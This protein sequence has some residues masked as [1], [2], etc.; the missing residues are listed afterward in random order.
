M[1]STSGPTHDFQ[2][3]SRE[4]FLRIASG[5]TDTDFNVDRANGG[6]TSGATRPQSVRKDKTTGMKGTLAR[7]AWVYVGIGLLVTPLFFVLDR[8][9]RGILSLAAALALLPAILIAYRIHRL[10]P[11]IVGMFSL[12]GTLY[13]LQEEFG[14]VEG[15][16]KHASPAF[17]VV[18]LAANVVVVS[19]LAYTVSRRRGNFSW[20]DIVDGLMIALAGWMIAWVML[21]QP[22]LGN[23]EH[24]LGE[25][26]LN[27]ANLPIMLPMLVLTIALAMSGV[28]RSPAT[29]LVVSAVLLS[30]IG[31]SIA[32]FFKFEQSGA[33][34]SITAVCFFIAL[35]LGGAAFVHPSSADLMVFAPRSHRLQLTRRLL[36]TGASLAL[37]MMLI[38]LVPSESTVD[39]YVKAIS[40]MAIVVLASIRI[41]E[42]TRAHVRA[43]DHL[44]ESALT[45]SL[46]GLPNRPAILDK[47]I[48]S[49][50]STGRHSGRPTLVIFDIDRF[51]NINDSLGHQAGDEVLR[52]VSERLQAAAES[53]GAVVGRRS[54]D[55]FMILDLNADTSDQALANAEFLHAVFKQPLS[56]S[57]GVVFLT[58]SGGV[59]TMPASGA[60]QAEDLFRMADIAMYKAKDAGRDGLALYR[61]SMQQHLTARMEIENALYGA[62]DRKE[63]RMFHQPIID[64]E[65]GNITGFESL[66]RWQRSDGTLLAPTQFIAIAEETGIISSIG[67]WAILEALNQLR[68]WIDGGL[69]SDRTTI[70]VNVS[71]RQLA[72]PHF[73]DSVTEALAR[74]RVSPS[75][76]WLEVTE[77]I[78]IAEPELARGALEQ[79]RAAGVR[80]SLDDFGTGYS[81][82]SLLQQFPIHQIK[83]DR[84]FV[85]GIAEG[86]HDASLVRTVI[87]M[88]ESLGMDV[89]AE[90]VET[91]QQ[92]AALRKL[93][94][95]KAQGYLISHPVPAIAMRS[96]IAALESLMA[97]EEFET[98]NTQNSKVALSVVSN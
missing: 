21:V 62:L 74:T 45:D 92:L 76:L 4:I 9:D 48:D 20:G 19:A 22:N 58:A 50:A 90:G 70:S 81:S 40:A 46:T 36:L 96:T 77:N 83:I 13:L 52:Q 25:F 32:M 8:S 56:V 30:I 10:P 17:A 37:P 64:L 71:P 80:I 29:W 7:V 35:I 53:I 88:G 34:E 65:A 67:S 11:A 41:V 95:S 44:V 91:V 26:I 78:M 51:K 84:S 23:P 82:L 72:D 93:G 15:A 14:V 33:T 31:D 94:C 2:I 1:G 79:L 98:G 73:A 68:S 49:I 66:M 47:A 16:G 85:S 69:V 75:L 55:E 18:T 27:A 6:T 24:N 42:A 60:A 59:A 87:A 61:D 3:D 5:P 86:G 63:L 97:A 28:I 54:G 38:A 12:I 89:V 39:R 57:E 43:Q